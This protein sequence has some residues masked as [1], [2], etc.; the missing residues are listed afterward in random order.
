MFQKALLG[1]L[2]LA[3]QIRPFHLSLLLVQLDRLDHLGLL[4]LMA[5]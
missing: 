3:G 2:V 5:L 1:H 4:V